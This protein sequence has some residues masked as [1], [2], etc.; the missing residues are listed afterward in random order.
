MKPWISLIAAA[1]GLLAATTASAAPATIRVES[2]T[3]A[4]EATD[5]ARAFRNIPYAPPPVGALP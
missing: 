2:G 1:C 3:L 5:R 4:G